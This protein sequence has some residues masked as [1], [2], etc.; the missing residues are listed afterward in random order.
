M[1]KWA[2]YDKDSACDVFMEINCFQFISKHS[3]ELKWLKD[4]I[5]LHFFFCLNCERKK[6]TKKLTGDSDDVDFQWQQWEFIPRKCLQMSA[7][8]M[9]IWS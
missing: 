5:R 1:K 6:L 7:I 8:I 3:T 9:M 4:L 2:F